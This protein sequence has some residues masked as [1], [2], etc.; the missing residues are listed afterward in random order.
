MSV[1]LAYTAQRKNARAMFPHE[2]TFQP[3]RVVRERD[4]L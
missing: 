2:S 3:M 4:M 1:P